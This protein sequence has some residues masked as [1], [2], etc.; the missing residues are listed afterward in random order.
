MLSRLY[1]NSGERRQAEIFTILQRAGCLQTFT[2][3]RRAGWRGSARWHVGTL[4]LIG[5]VPALLVLCEQITPLDFRLW[6]RG[7]PPLA[8]D[9]VR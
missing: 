8:L 7:R 3:L 6:R 1:G 5:S 2:I 9:D 4:P